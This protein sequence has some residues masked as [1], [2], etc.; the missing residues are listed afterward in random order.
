M[1]FPSNYY[2]II[3]IIATNASSLIFEEVSTEADDQVGE[4]YY[5]DYYTIPPAISTF[6]FLFQ[7]PPVVFSFPDTLLAPASLIALSLV[8]LPLPVLFVVVLAPCLQVF[9]VFPFLV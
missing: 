9:E 2:P 7:L 3:L 6:P 5:Q 8:G 4:V 1:S